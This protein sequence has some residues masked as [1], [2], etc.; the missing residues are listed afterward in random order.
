MNWT[1]KINGYTWQLEKRLLTISPL[2]L[3][4]FAFRLQ[5]QFEVRTDSN[6]VETGN[7]ITFYLKFPAGLGKPDS[8]SFEAWDSLVPA[9][10]ILAQT[11]W[12][13]EGGLFSKKITALFFDAD[14][15]QLPP[16]ALVFSSGDSTFSN[17][18]QIVVT[19]TPSPDDLND[20]APIKDIHREEDQWTDY[21]VWIMVVLGALVF[22]VW[23]IWMLNRKSKTRIK[24]RAFEIPAHVLALKKLDVL[25]LKQLTSKD[26]VKEHYAE[27]TFILREYLEKRFAIPALESTTEETLGFLKH[28]NFPAQISA[29]L[30][31]L[32]VQADLAKFAKI[33]PPESFHRVAL[34]ISRKIILQT[35]SNSD[36]PILDKPIIP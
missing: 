12:Q 34:D 16:L 14:S 23:I 1:T 30:H 6:H 21:W 9:Q 5:A 31:D 4:C 25:A 32:L 36:I 18:L 35:S 28:Q 15:L 7:P 29:E 3:V 24:S 8:V 19:A 2:I 17:P 11:D 10:N 20:M 13:V 27:L 26:L 33:I 22:L